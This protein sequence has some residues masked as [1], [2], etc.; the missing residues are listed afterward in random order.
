[1][2]L[3]YEDLMRAKLAKETLRERGIGVELTP[4][5]LNESNIV[6]RLEV[7]QEYADE[8][9]RHLRLRGMLGT[10]AA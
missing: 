1:M 10:I 4:N 3:D 8:A 9:A 6:H 5:F 2:T 7:N